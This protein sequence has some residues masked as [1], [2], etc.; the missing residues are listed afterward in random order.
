MFKK[1]N[2]YNNINVL[3]LTKKS[4]QQYLFQYILII[5]PIQ[6]IQKEII[7]K[8]EKGIVYFPEVN[9]PIDHFLKLQRWYK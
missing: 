4:Y 2:Y 9:F 3:I 1:I 5:L 8:S 7:K 6:K